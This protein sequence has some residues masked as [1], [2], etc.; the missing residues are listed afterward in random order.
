MKH[1]KTFENY[2]VNEEIWGLSKGEREESRKA[3]LQGELDKLLPA[4]TR[5]G[6]VNK[7][8]PEI[9]DKFWADAKADGYNGLPGLSSKKFPAD[10][11]YR[12]EKTIKWGSIGG[13]A[14]GS[15]E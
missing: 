6:A 7:P 8:T 15:G 5:K 3:K 9:L 11:M 1:L 13:H 2:S 4:W 14:F 12:P 10:L